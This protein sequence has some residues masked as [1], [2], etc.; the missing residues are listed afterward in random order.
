MKTVD[1]QGGSGGRRVGPRVHHIAMSEAREYLTLLVDRAHYANEITYIDKN[2]HEAAG[3][4]S[5][6]ATAVLIALQTFVPD[7]TELAK[8]ASDLPAFCAL[9]K[10]QL[11]ELQQRNAAD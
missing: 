6:A 5:P 1:D 8:R 3:V 4:V 11:D 10:A 9:L 2:R 7:L